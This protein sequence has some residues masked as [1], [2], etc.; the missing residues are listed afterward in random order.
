MKF[1]T[2]K[3]L[4]VL[5]AVS[6]L[7]A[8]SAMAQ[9]GGRGGGFAGRSAAP[10]F[11][12]RTFPGTAISSPQNRP[13]TPIP[14]MTNPV[15]PFVDYLNNPRGPQFNGRP[16]IPGR[17]PFDGRFDRNRVDIPTVIYGGSYWPSYWPYYDPLLY[18]PLVMPPPVPGQLP[19]VYPLDPTPVDP[20]VPPLPP[21][22]LPPPAPPADTMTY[23]PEPNVII[24]LDPKPAVLPALG[25]S[26][27]E[28]IMKNGDPWGSIWFRGKETL[29][30]RSGLQVGFVDGRVSDMQIK[31]TN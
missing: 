20:G 26:R 10:A 14:A 5:L 3:T 28:V 31:P 6:V 15:A 7:P 8:T 25:T 1:R 11:S 12:G 17:T 2:L 24:S 18:P 4:A 21:E 9:R 19:G 22:P 30:F 27:D 23:Y 16:V 29:Y 13:S